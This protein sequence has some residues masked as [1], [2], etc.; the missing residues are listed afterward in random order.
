MTDGVQR[1]GGGQNNKRKKDMKQ[2]TKVALFGG[3]GLIAIGSIAFAAQGYKDHRKMR[4][5]FS[6]Q[7]IL[8]ELDM[9]A[10]EAVSVEELKAAVSK[11]FDLADTDRDGRVNK[12]DVV[13]AIEANAPVERMKRHSGRLTDRIFMGADINSDGTIEMTE[14]ENRM[15]KFHAL[16]DWNDDGNVN[17]A[18]MKRLR[19]A[20]PGR[21][22]KRHGKRDD[23]TRQ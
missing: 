7:K 12:S 10:D 18:E 17:M 9:N 14:L 20:M 21:G 16:A 11:R 3:I 8:A 2:T 6:P 22:G 4:G 1:I 15:T 5:M 19:S 13:A 23:S